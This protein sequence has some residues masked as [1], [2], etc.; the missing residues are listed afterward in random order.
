VLGC[1]GPDGVGG[2]ENRTVE[3]RG[4]IPLT[5]TQGTCW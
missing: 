1:I 2:E 4:S 3:A 5:S